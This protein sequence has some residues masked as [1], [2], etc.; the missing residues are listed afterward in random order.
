MCHELRGFEVT[1]DVIAR[2]H[3]SAV[4]RAAVKDIKSAPLSARV[5]AAL[6]PC[7]PFLTLFVVL[8]KIMRDGISLLSRSVHVMRPSQSVADLRVERGC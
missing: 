4:S 7:P 2:R 1:C 6:C 5:F 3:S 8:K